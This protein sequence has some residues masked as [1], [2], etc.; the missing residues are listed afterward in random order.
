MVFRLTEL[1]DDL[2]ELEIVDVGASAIDGPVPY[3]PLIDAGKAHV[4]GFEPDPGQFEVLQKLGHSHATYLPYA[5][6]DGNDAELK[7]CFSPGMT[8]LLEPDQQV[9]AH[10]HGFSEWGKVLD[11]KQI[12]T[13]RLDDVQEIQSIDYLKL[14]VQGSELPIMRAGRK[15]LSETLVVHTEVNFVPFY[16]DQPLF[17]ELDQELRSAGFYL[18][19]FTPIVSRVFKPVI[20]NDDVF[21]GMSQSLWTDAVYVKKF[22]DFSK[23]STVDLLKVT[24]ILH[25][26]YNSFDLA[27]LA[28]YHIDQKEGS[29][30]HDAYIN[31]LSHG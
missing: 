14:D 8:S 10:F 23:M 27:A 28:L 19:R 18:H 3:Q 30:R 20:I 6:G 25:E 2:P 13:R 1:F 15:K 7:I 5:L 11:R 12:P 9:L 16:K 17:A 22:T 26:L 21:A 4:V 31:R 24:L 29:K